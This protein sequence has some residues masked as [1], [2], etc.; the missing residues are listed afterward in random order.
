MLQLPSVKENLR[1]Y[2]EAGY[3]ILYICTYE[4][5]K[6]DQYILEAAGRRKVIEWN[7][8]NGL[9]DFKTKS[10]QNPKQ[11][12]SLGA[13]LSFL[14]NDREL[15]RT[16]LVI[17]DADGQL[18]SEELHGQP[19][20]E[21]VTALLKEIAYKI[22]KKDSGIDATVIIVSPTLHI[23]QPLEKLITV[24]E[25]DLPDEKDISVI[26][27]NFIQDEGISVLPEKFQDE[28]VTAFKGLSE[29]EIKDILSL[30]Y[31]QEGKLTG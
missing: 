26:I 23:P 5:A 14:A 12:H 18:T 15:D 8:A 24:L 13:T 9:V 19:E 20:A 29:S 2:I 22:R 28:M 1:E 7:G 27:N 11:D 31:A 10:P 17:K 16:L 4:E 30:A 21:K 25:L 3:P 6:T